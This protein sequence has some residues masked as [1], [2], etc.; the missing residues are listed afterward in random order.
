MTGE[1]VWLDGLKIM[2]AQ[3]D[4]GYGATRVTRELAHTVKGG[5]EV[6]Q[7]ITNPYYLEREGML[8]VNGRSSGLV[9]CRSVT[10]R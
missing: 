1:L 8:S 9:T 2:H 6:S 4:W 10:C 3:T 7:L 5:L